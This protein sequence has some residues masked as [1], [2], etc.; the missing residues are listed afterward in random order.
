MSIRTLASALVALGVLLVVALAPSGVAA[1]GGA[2]HVHAPKHASDAAGPAKVIAAAQAELR[3]QMPALM[4]L[5]SDIACDR[6]CC[7]NGHCSACGTVIAPASWIAF[8]LSADILR[9]TRDSTVPPSLAFE[10]PPR[11]PKLL[12]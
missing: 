10:G 9:V 6:G 12:A 1:H 3:A 2:N 11:P 8:V 4:D 5:R 7:A